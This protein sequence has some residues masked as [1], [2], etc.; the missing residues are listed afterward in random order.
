MKK[1]IVLFLS[2][3][4]FLTFSQISSGSIK[5]GLIIANDE[6]FDKGPA[7]EFIKVAK[8][9]AHYLTFTLLFNENKSLFSTDGIMNLNDSGISTAV[10]ICGIYGN[11][12]TVKNTMQVLNEVEDDDLG[13]IIIEYQ[14]NSNWELLNE[15]KNIDGF[16]CFK[17][18]R[19]MTID[20]GESG[21]F[22][23]TIIA[24][25]C[26]SIPVS[27]GPAGEGGLPGLILELHNRNIVLGVKKI[28]LNPDKKVVITLPTKGKWVTE[29]EYSEILDKK[30]DEE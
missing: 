3:L 15:S 8:E 4:P 27:F 25:Y 17:A 23:R 1:I 18:S 20:N 30:T 6:D 11:F 9:S 21:I 24:W 22:K 19:I 13:K 16:T 28:D 5:Y 2:F 10:S 7:Q 26:P 29:K 14:N 12:Y